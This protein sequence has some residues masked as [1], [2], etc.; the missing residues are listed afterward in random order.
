M[1]EQMQE[2]SGILRN[3]GKGGLIDFDFP[4]TKMVLDENGKP[5]EIRPYERNVATKMIEDFCH[6]SCQRDGGG[7]LFLAGTSFRLPYP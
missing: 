2:L 6:A 5:V 4:E 7:R 3:R 1:F